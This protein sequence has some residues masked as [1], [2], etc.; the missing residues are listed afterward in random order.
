MALNCTHKIKVEESISPQFFTGLVQADGCFHV[1]IQKD[2]TAKHK[3]RLKPTFYVSQLN[4]FNKQIS[5]VLRYGR[6]L[7]QT[8]HYVADKT[9]NSSSL[10]VN[11][12]KGLMNNVLPHFERYPLLSRKK[13]NYLV[14]K[15]IVEKMRTKLYL[16]KKVFLDLVEKAVLMNN[17]GQS[18][19]KYKTEKHKNTIQTTTI[20]SQPLDS[21]FVS[22]L[23]QGDGSF[24]FSFRITKTKKNKKVPKV[25]PFF[26]LGQEKQN[27]D[28]LEKVKL[29]FKSGNLYPVS[30]NYSRWMV[31]DSFSLKE[32]VLPHFKENPLVGL[33]KKDFDIFKECLDILTKD[34][35]CKKRRVNPFFQPKRDTNC[36]ERV[37]ELCYDLNMGGK[38]R[39]LSK[40]EYLRAIAS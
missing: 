6:D 29:F 38:R 7:L 30:L 39:R 10:R 13:E 21:Q 22:G 20:N 19:K 24:G 3:I 15:E 33:K 16:D 18:L 12:L 14:F 36:V 1:N 25:S 5:P 40:E 27:K 9:S 8:G 23:F 37:I 28:L 31:T 35:E 2:N 32:N 11:T 17:K 4:T 26:T 34:Q